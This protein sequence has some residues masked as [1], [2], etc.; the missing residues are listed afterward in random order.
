MDETSRE[1]RINTA[2]V[3]LADTLTQD[4]DVV[5]LLNTLVE[6]CTEILDTD[7]GGLMLV[8]GEGQLQLMTSTNEA[9]DF[10]EVMQLAAASGPCIDCFKTGVPVSVPDIQNSGGRWPEFQKTALQNGFHSVHATPMRL[11]GQVIGTMNLFGTKRGALTDRDIAVAQALT[12]VATIGI[13]QERMIREGHVVAEQLHRA[14][15]SRVLIEQAK[16]MISHS[17]SIPMDEAFAVLR[18]HA[19]SNNLTI[20]AVSEGISNRTIAIQAI[21]P[22]RATRGVDRLTE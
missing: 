6:Q 16:G 1:T 7:A 17:M 3:A 5:D 14:L 13:L 12:D 20:R 22:S 10:V 8:D 15:D 9:A 2:F 18:A 21:V 11:R 19:R 4:F